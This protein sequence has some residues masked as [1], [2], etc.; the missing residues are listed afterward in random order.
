MKIRKLIEELID[1]E[2]KHGK[3]LEVCIKETSDL[4][5]A[6]LI[7]P[8]DNFIVSRHWNTNKSNTEVDHINLI[9]QKPEEETWD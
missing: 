4:N 7:D 9:R 8:G 5:L 3:D 1:I 6:S 2:C